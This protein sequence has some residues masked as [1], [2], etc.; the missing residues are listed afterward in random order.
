MQG[1]NNIS[2]NIKNLIKVSK[3]NELLRDIANLKE[4]INSKSFPEVVNMCNPRDTL[5]NPSATLQNEA[6]NIN[7]ITST[8][9]D[10]KKNASEIDA[11]NTLRD[12]RKKNI[13]RII[14]ATLNINSVS[15]KFDQLQCIITGNIDVLVITETKLDDSFP[16][17]KF[18]L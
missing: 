11:F 13:N 5:T 1:D 6:N 14:F 9:N 3:P 16:T 17:N 10:T 7:K 2:H 15:R 8:S 12:I 4:N 18:H